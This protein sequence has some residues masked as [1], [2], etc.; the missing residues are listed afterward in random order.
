MTAQKTS[1][2]DWVDI[3]VVG[4][5]EFIPGLPKGDAIL[6]RGDPGTG[7]TIVCLQFLYKGAKCGEKCIYITTEESPKSIMRAGGE[8]WPDFPQLVKKGIIQIVDMSITAEYSSEY[9]ILNK[10]EAMNIA[11]KGFAAQPGA[12]RIVIDSLSSLQRRLSDSNEFR[13]VFMKLLLETKQKGST[14]LLT[15]EGIPLTPDI[16]EYLVDHLIYLDYRKQDT[17]WTRVFILRKSRSVPLK[18]QILKL[19]I[20][21]GGLSVEE[22]PFALNPVWFQSKI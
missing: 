1:I 5:D 11:E 9:G 16:T 8:L 14:I 15:A 12:T 18:P 20:E 4:L 2:I 6:V 10:A 22:T 7:K 21:R 13:E 17:I 19:N 3:G